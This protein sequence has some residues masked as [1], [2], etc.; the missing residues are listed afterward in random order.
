MFSKIIKE[1]CTMMRFPLATMMPYAQCMV[2]VYVAAA[3]HLQMDWGHGHLNDTVQ[4]AV[5]LYIFKSFKLL[6]EIRAQ[7]GSK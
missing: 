3:L 6:F 5:K 4:N 2:R 1:C 7:A